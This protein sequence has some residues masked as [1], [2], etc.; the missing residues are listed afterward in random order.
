[1]AIPLGFDG[2]KAA[3]DMAAK[4]W[5]VADLARESKLSV[6]TVYRFLNGEVQTKKTARAIA[7]A[8]GFAVRRYLKAVEQEVAAS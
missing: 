7:E 5:E 2:A 8:M 1:M 4:G 6:R 3:Y